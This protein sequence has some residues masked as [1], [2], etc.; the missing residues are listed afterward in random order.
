ML[1]ELD[2]NIDRQQEQMNFV[3]GGLSRLLKTSD[4]KQLCT[5]IVGNA[6]G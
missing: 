6:G 4:H 2:E 5:V 1:S 3:M